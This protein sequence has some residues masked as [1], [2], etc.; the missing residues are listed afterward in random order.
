MDNFILAWLLPS[1]C[2]TT[3]LN[4]NPEPTANLEKA[5]KSFL[6][7]KNNTGGISRLKCCLSKDTSNKEQGAQR[8]RK[9]YLCSVADK[10]AVATFFFFPLHLLLPLLEMHACL[11]KSLVRRR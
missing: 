5:S 9:R 7:A 10:A 11:N 6:K 1:K 3:Y 2:K 8:I 4:A